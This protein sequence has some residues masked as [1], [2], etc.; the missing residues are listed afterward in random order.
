MSI[1]DT[2][3]KATLGIGMAICLFFL[4]DTC[5]HNAT[6]LASAKEYHAYKDTVKFYKDKNNKMVSYNEALLLEGS[7]LRDMNAELS[8]KLKNLLLE[9]VKEFN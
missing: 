8:E 5:N 6:L 2:L 1:S 3:V 4:V 7:T 9:L